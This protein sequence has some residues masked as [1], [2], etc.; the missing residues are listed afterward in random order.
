MVTKYKAVAALLAALVAAQAEAPIVGPGDARLDGRKLAAGGIT[1]RV[2]LSGMGPARD[3]GNMTQ[4]LAAATFD[5]RPGTLSIQAWAGGPIDSSFFETRTL[6]PLRERSHNPSRYLSLDFDSMRI[7][8]SVTTT[9]RKVTRVDRTLERAAF[10]AN[11]MDL[12]VAALPLALRF[13]AR[14]PVYVH[15]TGALEMYGVRVLGADSVKTATGRKPAWM[16][17]VQAKERKVRYW[18][19]KLSHRVWRS[20]FDLG[21]GMVLTIVAQ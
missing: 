4:T 15:D 6:K 1:R 12:V 11:T 17:E 2:T 9:D 3:A 13:S 8:G 10:D 16:V 5:G 20:E 14:I 21:R 19:D 18:V 7:T